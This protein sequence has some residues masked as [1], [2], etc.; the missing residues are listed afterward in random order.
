[1]RQ[2]VYKIPLNPIK[3]KVIRLLSS[4][5]KQIYLFCSTPFG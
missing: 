3:T 5:N 1:V 4:I 2:S